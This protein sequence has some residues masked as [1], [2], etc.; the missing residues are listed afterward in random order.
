MLKNEVKVGNL[1]IGGNN[2]LVL[3]TMLK[4]KTSN[5]KEAIEQISLAKNYGIN[6]VRVSILDMEDAKAIK[7]IKERIDVNLVADIHFDYLL[8]I[9]SINNGVDK[10]RL[11]PSNITNEDN[12]REVIDKCKE[13]NIP[14]RIGLNGGSLYKGQKLDEVKLLSLLDKEVKLLEKHNFYNIVISIKVNNSED[15][16]KINEQID[17]TYPYPI[18][19]G[20]TEAGG[21]IDSLIKSSIFTDQMIKK[22]IGSTIRFSVYGSLLDEII[23]GKRILINLKQVKGINLVVCPTCGRLQY[24]FF[25]I[26][27]QIES[28]CYASNKNIAVALMGCVVN[29]PGEAQNANIAIVGGINK[30][31]FYIDGV[32]TKIVSEDEVIRVFVEYLNSL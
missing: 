4:C 28:I 30:V 10:I 12:L 23:V 20:V 19:L 5:T 32:Q 13:K 27:K 8:A 9:E 17:K 22:G 24:N 11:N 2:P 3:Q 14:I 25:K 29:G 31:A 18:H 15:A 7:E 6:L 1:I 26:Y 21:V 16:I